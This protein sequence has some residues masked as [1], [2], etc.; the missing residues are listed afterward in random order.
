MSLAWCVTSRR[1]LSKPAAGQPGVPCPPPPAAWLQQ[2]QRHP[3]PEPPSGPAATSNNGVV[4]GILPLRLLPQ[5][6]PQQQ[7][8]QPAPGLRPA[9]DAREAAQHAPPVQLQLQQL[10]QPPPLD[11]REPADLMAVFQQAR[12]L[13][14]SYGG[15]TLRGLL[16]RLREHE[17]ELLAGTH[18]CLQSQEQPGIDL[19]RAV[20]PNEAA[21]RMVYRA[22]LVSRS[23]VLAAVS[24]DSVGGDRSQM[25]VLV[26][27]AE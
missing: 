12:Q 20:L 8:Q 22:H 4:Y 15:S 10:L 11:M 23:I 9:A 14:L 17:A 6:P 21:V 27:A 5:P 1:P 3:P 25:E 7:Q 16:V 24:A 19:L 13:S 18:S 2:Q 26:A